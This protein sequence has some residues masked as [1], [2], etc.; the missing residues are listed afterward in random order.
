MNRR[1]AACPA[2][3]AAAASLALVLGL[4]PLPA[5]ERAAAREPAT[6]ELIASRLQGLERSMEGTD[7]TFQS[8]AKQIDDV[9][10]YHRVGDICTIDKV[11][12]NRAPSAQHTQSDRPGRRQPAHHPR[13][14]L[15]SRK[16]STAARSIPCLCTCTAEC[17]PI[18]PR[19]AT[20]SCAK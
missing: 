18:S 4:S 17:T 11:E 8:L 3:I 7:F 12:Y 9:L 5:Q 16:T 15:S 1:T 19:E 20:A 10:W 2:G 6:L 13:L 14:Q